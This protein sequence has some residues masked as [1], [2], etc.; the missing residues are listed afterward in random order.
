MRRAFDHKTLTSRA[1]SG[2][3]LGF[4]AA[5]LCA[6]TLATG[7]SGSGL[8]DQLDAKQNQLSKVEHTKGVLTSTIT[9]YSGQISGLQNQVAALQNQLSTVQHQLDLRQAELDRAEA[10]L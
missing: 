1:R 10:Q 5:A 7:A 6:L 2:L 8:D 4:L 3:L 9:H